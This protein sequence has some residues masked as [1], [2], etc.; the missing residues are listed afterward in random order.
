MRVE[1]VEI[2]SKSNSTISMLFIDGKHKFFIVEDGYREV[3]VPGETRIPAG[4]YSLSRRYHG[5]FFQKYKHDY[6]HQFAL[7]ILGIDGFEDVLIHIGN[8][9]QDTRGCLLVN[10]GFK[11]GPDGNYVGVESAI[12]YQAFYKIVFPE[13]Q[14]D[15]PVILVV[16]RNEILTES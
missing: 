1:I 9:N 13:L 4:V 3:K 11:I 7:E 5:K 6:N 2:A 16:N 14:A 12:A 15:R 8:T 10:M